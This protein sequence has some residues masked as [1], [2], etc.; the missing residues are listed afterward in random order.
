M[1]QF[2]TENRTETYE[3]TGSA[4]MA[5]ASDHGVGVPNVP[6]YLCGD[7]S[8]AKAFQYLIAGLLRFS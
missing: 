1:K 2:E 8:L 4:S 5:A 6:F 7:K 3:K